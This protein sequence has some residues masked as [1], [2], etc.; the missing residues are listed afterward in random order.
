MRER[1]RTAGV[2][3]V[4]AAVAVVA[5]ADA[6]RGGSGHAHPRT[7]P[8]GPAPLRAGV[9]HG[10]L[11]YADGRC[12]VHRIDLATVH[13]R[14]LTASGGHCRFWVSPDRRFVAMHPGRPFTPPRDLE[15]LDVATGGITTPFARPDL[16]FAPPAWSPDSQTLVACDARGGTPAVRAFH[17]GDGRITTPA[18]GGC[19]PGYVGRRLVYRDI[20]SVAHL[21]GRRVI[22]AS[23]L[24]RLLHTGVYQEP[25]PAAGGG[26]IAVPATTVTP[27]GG[28]P[29][30]T[31]V[32][33]FDAAGRAVGRWDTGAVADAVALLGSG[34]VIAV[35]RGSGL[36]L[37]DRAT[38]RVITSAAG[39]PIVSAAVAPGGAGLALSD[40]RRILLCRMDGR[41]RFA[42]PV[43][44]R[45]LA[46]TR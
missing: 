44:T 2:L 3:A 23:T 30:I 25:A 21:G 20:D 16:A 28:P 26:V 17:L 5:A 31:T 37:D 27:A 4:V 41:V 40:G 42:L 14:T 45:W 15:L 43:R 19:Y 39:R 1:L 7:A 29:P 46:W 10:S 9:L 34:R 6:L 24:V 33:V 18:E 11:W 35:S 36:I 32:V 13:D 38:R 12:R 22:D 8:A